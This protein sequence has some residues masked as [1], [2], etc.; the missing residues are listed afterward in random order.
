MA[1]LT[2]YHLWT[3]QLD[4]GVYPE[5]MQALG[6]TLPAAA[7]FLAREMAAIA[8]SPVYQKTAQKLIGRCRLIASVSREP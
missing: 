3:D 7:A 4:H 8:W 6:Y 1:T 2:D 5:T